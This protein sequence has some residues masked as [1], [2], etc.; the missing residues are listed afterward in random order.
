MF[1][2]QL[3]LTEASRKDL[4]LKHDNYHYQF[5]VSQDYYEQTLQHGVPK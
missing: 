1:T 5:P 3:F 4:Y 2:T